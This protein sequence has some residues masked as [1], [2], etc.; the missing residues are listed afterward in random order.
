VKKPIYAILILLIS[1]VLS[2]CRGYSEEVHTGLKVSPGFTEGEKTVYLLRYHLYRTPLGIRRFPDGGQVR[3][4]LKELYVMELTGG[5]MTA[6]APLRDFDGRNADIAG[7]R[8]RTAEEGTDLLLR[9]TK[10]GSWAIIRVRPDSIGFD[11]SPEA[12][13]EDFPLRGDTGITGISRQTRETCLT[14]LGLP[15]PLLYCRKNRNEYIRDVVELKGDLFYRKE[16]IRTVNL[17]EAEIR[18]I[19]E[20]M[21]RRQETLT[22]SKALEYRIYSEETREALQAGGNK[23]R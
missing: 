19:L 15:S 3:T 4:L 17:S 6:R 5:V 2:C 10:E 12:D 18:G 7:T 8:G 1:Y 14:C 16:V 9:N 20:K 13:P 11:D 21:N 23:Q 22:G